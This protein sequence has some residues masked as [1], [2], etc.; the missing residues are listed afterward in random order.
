MALVPLDITTTLGELNLGNEAWWEELPS[1]QTQQQQQQQH[2]VDWTLAVES[3][4]DG[5]IKRSFGMKL[6]ILA[7]KS[8]HFKV[9]ERAPFA[10]GNSKCSTF[11]FHPLVVQSFDLVLRFFSQQDFITKNLHSNKQPPQTSSD[12]GHR[13]FC[14]ACQKDPSCSGF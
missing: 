11:V 12:H 1:Q 7:A 14:S 5:S 13:H 4:D 8:Q 6:S 3:E 10:E 2:L 9:M